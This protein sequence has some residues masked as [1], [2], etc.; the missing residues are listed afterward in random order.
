VL[1][2]DTDGVSLESTCCSSTPTASHSSRRAA[3]RHRRRL[4][5]VDVLLVDTDGSTS[6]ILSHSATSVHSKSGRIAGRVPELHLRR[7]P[8]VS[9]R[10][11]LQVGRKTTTYSLPRPTRL[12]APGRLLPFPRLSARAASAATGRED[13]DAD[14]RSSS[15]PVLPRRRPAALTT[16]C[17]R[18]RA[19]RSETESLTRYRAGRTRRRDGRSRTCRSSRSSC[20]AATAAAAATTTTTPALGCPPER[21]AAA[22]TGASLSLLSGEPDDSELPTPRLSDVE[23]AREV[24]RLRLRPRRTSRS[25][26]GAGTAAA[27]ALTT[28]R[29]LGCPPERDAAAA[30]AAAERLLTPLSFGQRRFDSSARQQSQQN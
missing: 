11:P 8:R 12:D 19:R 6:S 14:A 2:V 15:A 30:P 24:P 13:G 5:R 28:A 10:R 9:T 22:A 27:P 18:L 7:C 29:A 3:R 23:L 26:C 4:A 16:R 20:G 21:D 1:L 25:S 17:R